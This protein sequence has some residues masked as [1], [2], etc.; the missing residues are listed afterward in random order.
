[1]SYFQNI[2]VL[3]QKLFTVGEKI[4]K[5]IKN[6]PQI[7]KDAYM[8]KI[9]FVGRMGWLVANTKT[10]RKKLRKK[11]KKGPKNV[12]NENFGK[13][14]KIIKKYN[15]TIALKNIFPNNSHFRRFS[16]VF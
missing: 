9:V 5:I 13:R 15:F 12:K 10:K 7:V 14:K 4:D 16:G 8:P 11:V 6:F 3:C 2:R 1:M